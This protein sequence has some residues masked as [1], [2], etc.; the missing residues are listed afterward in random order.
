MSERQTPATNF[1]ETNSPDTDPLAAIA[2][3]PDAQ[4][5]R[6]IAEGVAKDVQP[7]PPPPVAPPPL[8]VE[9]LRMAAAAGDTEAMLQLG[10]VTGRGGDEPGA[11]AW[12]RRAAD[13]GNAEGM[14][15][16]GRAFLLAEGGYAKD[17]PTAKAWY[18]RAGD[19]GY[20]EGY[21]GIG[22]IYERGRLGQ[23]DPD[24]AIAW[25]TRAAEAGD[26]K[27]MR[28]AGECW[29]A[30]ARHATDG[31]TRQAARAQALQWL[32]R[33]ALHDD[34]PALNMLAEAYEN[35]ED[36][37]LVEQDLAVAIRLR[38]RLFALGGRGENTAN[39]AL[40][41]ELGYGCR[42][43]ASM[44]SLLYVLSL[45]EAEMDEY[46]EFSLDDPALAPLRDRAYFAAHRE[47]L[48]TLM[49][50]GEDDPFN[51]LLRG[52]ARL[53]A[54]QDIAREYMETRFFLPPRKAG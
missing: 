31:A 38:Q 2:F 25:Y 4:M 10:A 5:L 18:E 50:K 39:L 30:K 21:W 43:N 1:P 33:A 23:S 9:A 32:G 3:V 54:D 53:S 29:D 17:V 6:V 20:A 51:F 27:S 14:F 35:E 48:C 47:E 37:G 19:A 28:A 49:G 46:E 44:A 26:V 45:D 36:D 15:C 22:E 13:A 16:V 24:A 52:I 34:L 12:F 11:V 40:F 8:A 41:Y 42:A 7:E